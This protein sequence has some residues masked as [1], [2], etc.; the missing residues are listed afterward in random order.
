MQH[1]M[2]KEAQTE[3]YSIFGASMN[4]ISS[5]KFILTSFSLGTNLTKYAKLMRR[6][7]VTPHPRFNYACRCATK[8]LNSKN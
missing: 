2:L 4:L 7:Y 3:N 5:I 1:S 8:T 6:V